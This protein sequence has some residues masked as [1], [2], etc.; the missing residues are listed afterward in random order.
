ML[1]DNFCFAVKVFKPSEFVIVRL[2]STILLPVF[3]LSHLFCSPFPFSA[4]FWIILCVSVLAPLLTYQLYVIHCFAILVDA[5]G[6]IVPILIYHGLPSSE[7][8][9]FQVP[10]CHF[11]SPSLCAIF[12]I[13]FVLHML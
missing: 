13:Y 1:S 8:V 6:F 10:V 9:L 3:N 12:V 11:S 7:I 4:L 2:K 5:L